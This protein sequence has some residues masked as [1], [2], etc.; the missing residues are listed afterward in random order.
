MQCLK[1]LVVAVAAVIFFCASPGFGG[2]TSTDE[3]AFEH[4]FDALIHP[5]ELRAWMKLLAAEP[6]HVSSRHDKANA[7]Q[8]LVWFKAGDGTHTS[9]RS[10]CSIRS[11]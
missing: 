10:R 4:N 8:I 3:A 11:R 2:P 6:N 5:E 9:K 1:N 7:D